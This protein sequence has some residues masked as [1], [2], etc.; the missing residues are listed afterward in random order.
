MQSQANGVYLVPQLLPG[1]YRIQ[2][3]SPGFKRLDVD[4]LKVDV[5]TTLTQD[6]VLQVGGTTET[7]VVSGTTSLVETTS[8]RVGTTV[9]VSQVLEMPLV[10][11][12]VFNLVNLVPTAA[13]NNSRLSIGGGRTVAVSPRLD[14]VNNSRGEWAR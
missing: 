4:R 8:G 6:L 5:G 9:Q 7:I 10:D 13:L 2:A 3:E 1:D 14:G 12:N 11:R